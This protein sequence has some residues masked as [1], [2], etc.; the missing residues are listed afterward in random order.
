MNGK[1][2][3]NVRQFLL[4]F[5]LF[6]IGTSILL[7][8]STLSFVANESAWVAVVI[9]MMVGIMIILFF[10]LISKWH[11]N[12]NIVDLNRLLFGR[13]IG[14]LLSLLFILF[15]TLTSATVLWT[16]GHFMITQM[17]HETPQP[18]IHILFM[19]VVIYGVYLGIE[20]IARAAELF[21]PY[22][23]LLLL[24]IFLFSIPS[25][26][27]NHI[28]PLLDTSAPEVLKGAWFELSVST[29][30]LIVLFMIYPKLVQNKK[31]TG[32]KVVLVYIL[33]LSSIL[34]ATFI[35]TSVLGVEYT[36]HHIYPTYVL[37]KTLNI[38]GL[39]QRVEVIIA[40]SWILATFFKLSLYFYAFV[41]ALSQL[42]RVKSYRSLTFPLGVL[43]IALSLI[44]YPSSIYASEWNQKTWIYYSTTFGVVYPFAIA[45]A[46]LI[47]KL[48]K[49]S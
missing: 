33:A 28:K 9:G 27:L 20:T 35:T 3:I 7:S 48:L 43:V 44:V 25:I 41:T 40:V 47:R 5:F 26:D 31:K 16:I 4:L 11:P 46:T 45:I 18:F 37:A 6:M 36:S 24:V 10:L 29:F 22:V 19:F 38:E 13:W 23:V 17:L 1:E 39:I 21:F 42:L 12:H 15:S 30:P 49:R 32:K 14:T 8:P 34:A 2:K